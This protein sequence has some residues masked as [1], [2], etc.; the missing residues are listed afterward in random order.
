MAKAYAAAAGLALAAFTA[1]GLLL[2][3]TIPFHDWDSF[4]FGSWSRQIATG[5]S[6]D[7]IVSGQQGSGRPLYFLLQGA[8]WSVTGV[9]FTAGRILSLLFALLLVA[10]VAWIAWQLA[11]NLLHVALAVICLVAVA[12]LA[13]EAVASKTDIPAAALVATTLALAMGRT[14]RRRDWALLCVSAFAAMLTKA[15]VIAP[16]LGLG[17]WLLLE[18]SRPLADRIRWS[19]APLAA[20]MILGAIYLQVMASRF[21]VSLIAFLQTGASDGLWAQRAA[22]DRRDAMLR[23]D[24]FGSGL[25]VP[26]AFA[27]VYCIA[28]CCGLRHRRSAVV[29]LVLGLAWAVAGPF[30]AH[31]PHGPFSTAEEG[32]TFVGFAVLLAFAAFAVEDGPV[33][34]E[35]ALLAAV[36]IP[37]LL[38]WV[39][40]TAYFNRLAATSWPALVPLI[41]VCLT[42]GIE[43]L[44]A[45]L[46]SL[47]ALAA[48]PVL[49]VAV[50]LALITFDAFD[51]A[52]WAEYR[53]LGISGLGSSERTLNIVLP[54]VQST[55]A[56]AQPY[57]KGGGQI[58]VGDPRFDWFLPQSQVSGD[59]AL[60][61]SDLKG[62]SVFVLLT[63]D[64]SEAAAQ[65]A[66]GLATP[67]QWAKCTSPHLKQ[68]TDGSNGYAVFAVT[69]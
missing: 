23:L 27:L 19:V 61:C 37:P 24:V 36:G 60:K 67:D 64:E 58:S 41:A 2:A 25:R 14:Q 12:P 16:L 8:L 68:L 20:G 21:H 7:P 57:L 47:S 22:A 15:T 10:A 59:A 3:V 5:G 9:S 38:L 28:R 39:Y 44:R 48:I 63:S 31:L 26:L 62:F 29:A 50:W 66:G 65:D 13:Q 35:Y 45:R 51:G 54:S 11:R 69:S 53:S 55:I 40:A 1:L 6:L 43:G 34:S 42:F 52:Q 18:R 4:A 56:T 17:A 30:A 46:G 33:R 49:A 32:F